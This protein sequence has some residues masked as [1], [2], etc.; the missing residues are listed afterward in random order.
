M[1]VQNPYDQYSVNQAYPTSVPNE[2]QQQVKQQQAALET[3]KNILDN[4]PGLMGDKDRQGFII[5]TYSLISMMLLFTAA[6][7]ILTYTTP[8]LKEFV[9]RN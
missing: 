4:V 6:F 7:C 5:K 9:I 8:A 1:V 2:I 3:D